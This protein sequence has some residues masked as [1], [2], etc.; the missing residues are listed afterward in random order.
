MDPNNLTKVMDYFHIIQS[1]NS[2]YV[3][4]PNTFRELFYGIVF[5]VKSYKSNLVFK[6]INS[7]IESLP[8]FNC[9]SPTNFLLNLFKIHGIS[10]I[11]TE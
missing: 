6:R 3:E 7:I 5:M 8:K 9:D 1:H 11:W 4:D 10:M 2:E